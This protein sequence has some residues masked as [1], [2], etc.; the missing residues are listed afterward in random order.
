VVLLPHVKVLLGNKEVATWAETTAAGNQLSIS[1][2][3]I[4]ANT[5][6]VKSDYS[7]DDFK[8][9]LI[10]LTDFLNGSQGLSLYEASF[11]QIKDSIPLLE[12]IKIFY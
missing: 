10:G 7:L 12:G 2:K 8:K 5:Q 4:F 1:L 3:K 9:F 6:L 11:S